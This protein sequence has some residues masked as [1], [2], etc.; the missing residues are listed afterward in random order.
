VRRVEAHGE[1]YTG[2]LSV[3]GAHNRANAALASAALRAL[4]VDESRA[5]LEGFPGLSHR[6]KLVHTSRDGVRWYDDSKSTVPEATAL[7][8]RAFGD[9]AGRLHL[10]A[11]GYD[12][13]I[14]LTGIAALAGQIASCSTIG[15]T[16][17]AIAA[18]ARGLGLSDRCRECGTLTEAVR[19]IGGVARAGDLVVLSPG[20]ASWDQFENYEHRGREFARLAVEMRP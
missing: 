1:E 3:P 12:K 6:L 5:R 15:T 2:R 11:G 13:K 14:D 8:V 17:P 18:A 9:E 16:G 7:A 10:I 20:C 19:H 4:G